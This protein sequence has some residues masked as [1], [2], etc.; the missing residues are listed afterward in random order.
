MKISE[1]DE[2]EKKLRREVGRRIAKARMEQKLTQMQLARKLGIERSRLGK[3]EQGLHAPL[4]KQL[5]ALSQVLSL[6]LDELIL[7]RPSA[8]RSKGSSL[9]PATRET[10][11]GMADVLQELLE[12][13]RWKG[14]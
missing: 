13:N 1:E 3:W 6:S 9:E 4:L 2:P 10:L 7:G 11:N 12:R 5:A 14:P 8:A